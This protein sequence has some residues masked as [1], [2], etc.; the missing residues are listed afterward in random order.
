MTKPTTCSLPALVQRFFAHYLIT[1]RQLSPCTVASYRDTLRLLL[2]YVQSKT[3]RDPARQ[4]LEDWDAPCILGFLEYLE[5]QRQCCA[6]SRNAR[7]AAIHCFMRFAAQQ[8]PGCLALAQRVLAIPTKRQSQPILG[9]L[10]AQEVQAI[11]EAPAQDTFSGRRDHLL[12]QL[13]YNTGARVS[14]IVALNRQDSPPNCQT[15]TLHG[16]G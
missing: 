16:K 10:T 5:K 6:R 15:V 11:L 4:R 13:L 14:E 8:E 7:L 1:V 9:F 2:L 12:F 3:Q